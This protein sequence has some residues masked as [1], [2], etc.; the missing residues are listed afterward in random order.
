VQ[1]KI[2]EAQE[3]QKRKKKR[4]KEKKKFE[5]SKQGNNSTTD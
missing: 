3:E 2:S 1:D 4:K 5:I